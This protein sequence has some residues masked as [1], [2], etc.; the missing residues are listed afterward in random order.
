[1]LRVAANSSSDASYHEQVPQ[2][3]DS[4]RKPA[5]SI[6]DAS[7]IHPEKISRSH[8]RVRWR[9]PSGGKRRPGVL[10]ATRVQL[11]RSLE[12]R[13]G[14]VWLRISRAVAVAGYPIERAVNRVRA[15]RSDGAESLLAM[16]VA[17][18]YLADVRT[19]F[20][21]KPRAERGPWQRYTLPDLAQLAYGAQSEAELR[22]ARRS[23]DMLV[24]IGW[25]FPSKQ[26]RRYAEDG[27]FRSEPAVRRLNLQRLCEMTG[28]TW[29][30]TRDR[31]HADRARGNGSASFEPGRQRPK[32]RH[33]E[34]VTRS[35]AVR[36]HEQRSRSTGDP[37][38][39]SSG[40]LQHVAH[41]LDLLGKG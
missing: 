34:R 7:S 10:D 28:T 21:G 5:A 17:L 16:V 4:G 25:A 36:A 20:I 11:V 32:E 30:L 35:D 14:S 12:Q 1:M 2:L 15:L 6:L 26:V 22:R 41:I 40:P 31:Q 39:Q 27:N 9:V 29:L 19:G 38:S 18:L 33:Q 37:P 23:L 8:R 3:A 13:E 24:S